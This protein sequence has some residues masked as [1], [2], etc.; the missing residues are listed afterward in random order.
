MPSTT[1]ARTRRA[2]VP[3]LTLLPSLPAPVAAQS[4][5]GFSGQLSAL[6]ATIRAGSESKLGPGLEGQLR[7][8]RLAT[9]ERA[10]ALSLGL[11]AQYTTHA[12]AA[13]RDLTITGVFLEPRF[14][15][16]QKLG[17]VFPYIAG[18]LAL[19]RQSN[20]FG[21]SSSGTAFGAGG[22]VAWPITRRVN[23]DVGGA[24]VT[25]SFGDVRTDTGGMARFP[26]FT[27]WVGKAGLSLG[28]GG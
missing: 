22:G 6:V 18:R 4:A 25:Q 10:G 8:N 3:L 5:Q 17:P 26:G 19:L 23:L 9:S 14:A 27:T 2:L 13:S 1:I 12:L 7:F 11:G 24:I 16:A 21:G 20:N 15:F 28:F